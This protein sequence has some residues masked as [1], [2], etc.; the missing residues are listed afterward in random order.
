MTTDTHR[1]VCKIADALRSAGFRAFG[2]ITPHNGETYLTLDA[3]N[4]RTYKLIFI[5]EGET[6]DRRSPFEKIIEEGVPAE[7]RAIVALEA[8]AAMNMTSDAGRPSDA[9]RSAVR[10]YQADP[11]A[12]RRT[13]KLARERSPYYQGR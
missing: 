13:F 5:D 12:F 4:G 11:E 10:A 9:A 8:H 3:E 2:A 7:D 6:P 1:A